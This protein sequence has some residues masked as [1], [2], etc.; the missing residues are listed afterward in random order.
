MKYPNE[1]LRNGNEIARGP[2]WNIL[3]KNVR[4]GNEI[5]RGTN[6]IS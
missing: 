1:N 3:M 6:E 5:A 2:Q 4:N